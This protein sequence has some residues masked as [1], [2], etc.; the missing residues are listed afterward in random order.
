[1]LQTK[2]FY[3]PLEKDEFNLMGKPARLIWLSSFYCIRHDVAK[4][5]NVMDELKEYTIQARQKELY[6]EQLERIQVEHQA[7]VSAIP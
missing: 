7:R 5:A 6:N 4:L 1:M 3:R 2:H